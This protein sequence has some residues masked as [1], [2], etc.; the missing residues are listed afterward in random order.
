MKRVWL[1]GL[2]V[3]MMLCGQPCLGQEASSEDTTIQLQESQS[4]LNKHQFHLFN[5]VPSD[6][7]RP[8]STDRPDKTESAYTVDAGH[9]QFEGDLLSLILN[10]DTESSGFDLLIAPTNLKFGI[11]NNLDF[12]VIILPVNWNRNTQLS[13]SKTTDTWSFGDMLLR[14]KYNLWGND[15]GQ[16]ALAVMPFLKLPT[17]SSTTINNLLEGGVVL[18][19]A[20]DIGN[21]WGFGAQLQM[22]IASNQEALSPHPELDP[23]HGSDSQTPAGYHPEFSFAATIGYD[24]TDE[25]GAFIEIFGGMSTLA[26][27]EF[28]STFDA[29]VT[30]SPTPNMQ[31]D[32]GVYLGLTANAPRFTPFIGLSHRF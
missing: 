19:F 9:F 11:L 4:L 7:M 23:R 1:S 2:L 32:M 20:W 6:M 13:D 22:D 31:W 21:N 25:I 8:M 3:S 26:P 27:T 12:H 17:S 16:T 28:L 30:W 10:Q 18:P 15:G 24:F 14:M 5:P 29:G